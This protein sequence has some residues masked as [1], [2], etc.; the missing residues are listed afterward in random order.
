[1]EFRT[2]KAHR[3]VLRDKDLLKYLFGMVVIIIVYLSAWTASNINF[4]EEGF[5]LLT[6]GKS[7]DGSH[8]NACKPLWWEYVTEAGG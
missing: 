2:R 1:M 8:F 3:L 5:S 4:I 6:I 7:E